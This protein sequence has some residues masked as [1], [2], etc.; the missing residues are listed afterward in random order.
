MKATIFDIQRGSFVDGPGIRTTVFF[1]GCNLRCKWCHNPEGIDREIK[2]LFYESKCIGCKKCKSVCKSKACIL[3]GEC[4]IYCPSM[5]REICG[6]EIT[7]RELFDIIARDKHYY[8]NGGG[9]TF[10][11]GE[12]LLNPDFLRETLSLCK[13]NGIGTAI[14]T[15]GNV[16][17]ESIERVMPYTDIFLYD[18]KCITK[19]LHKAGTG[20]SNGLILENLKRLKKD[21][22]G[23]IIIRIPIIGGFNDTEEELRK[24]KAFLDSLEI[25]EVEILPYHTLGVHKYEALGI[26]QTEFSVPSEGQMSAFR[27][28]FK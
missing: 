12:C 18:I 17:Y 3:C 20:V 4:A 10:S 24:I 28:I 9:A 6:R 1:K 15:A 11:G 2:M 5:A 26:D 22:C 16:P 13:E 25:E 21:F 7:P 23:R 19:E 8:K 27:E 14:D